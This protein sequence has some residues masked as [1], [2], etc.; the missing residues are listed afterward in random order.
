MSSY[1]LYGA[2]I[3]WN[4]TH[5]PYAIILCMGLIRAC[6]LC[7]TERLWLWTSASA[8][9]RAPLFMYVRLCLR[10]CAPVYVSEPLL[11]YVCF[12]L[13]TWAS[14]CVCASLLVYVRLCLCMCASACVRASLLVYVRLCLCMCASALALQRHNPCVTGPLVQIKMENMIYKFNLR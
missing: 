8:C 4:M 9:V 14:A 6:V 11:V 2:R 10:T 12:C 3:E 5:F 1:T 7:R 13:Y